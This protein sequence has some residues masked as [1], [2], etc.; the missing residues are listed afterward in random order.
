M[1][2]S[3]TLPHRISIQL[4]FR[5]A[6]SFGHVNNAVFATFAELGRV[7]FWRDLLDRNVGRDDEAGMILAHLSLDFR[8]Q[9][10]LSDEVSVIT[11]VERIGT[12]SV[13]MRQTV[14]RGEETAV[15]VSSVIVFFDY[16]NQQPVPIPAPLRTRLEELLAG[17]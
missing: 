17:N 11:E 6:D 5:D 10:H 16:V 13:G 7:S 14:L 8:Q 4:R 3:N 2:D 15:D 12:S 9:V 1:T